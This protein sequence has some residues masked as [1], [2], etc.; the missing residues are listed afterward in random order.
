MRPNQSNAA[1]K[2]VAPELRE[3]DEGAWL[4]LDAA[5]AGTWEIRPITGEHFLS[6]RSRELLGIEGGEA[7]SIRRLL[8]ALDPEDRE[9]WKDAV[10]RV[11][12]AERGGECH[13]EFRTAGREERWLAASGR[14]FFEGV[15]AVRVTGTLWDVSERRRSEK[16]RDVRIGE[17]GHDLRMP[18][19]TISMGINLVQR[20]VPEKAQILLA[21]QFT[22]QRMDRLIDQLLS[23]ARSGTG[24][25]VL[26]RERVPL[27]GICREAI[28]EASLAY[29][30][31]PIEFECWD[32]AP[33]EWDRDRLLQVVQN[34]LS[35]ALSH[36][37][38]GEPVIVSVIDCSEDALLSVANRGQPIADPFREQ[39]F[40][41]TRRGA[42]SSDHLG[43]HIVKEIVGAH[44]GR[45]DLTSDDSATVFHV[46]L[47]K[48]RRN[49]ESQDDLKGERS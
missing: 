40:D 20:N 45:I 25:L 30:D 9:R 34:L 48:R 12:D 1:A 5:G 31:H 21:M 39:L 29:P 13:L 6:A 47:P 4:A 18:L 36:G 35:N 2:L 32:D 41:P 16:E 44:G 22:V 19:N 3:G 15:R 26:K 10:A 28:E 23:F 33:G 49:H 43:L 17:L 7:I 11:L 27:A 42:W 46:W 14:A 8:D 38:A 37:A 24:R